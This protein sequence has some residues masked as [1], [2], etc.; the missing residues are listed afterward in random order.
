MQGGR[1]VD[2]PDRGEGNTA[3]PATAHAAF[4]EA[5]LPHLDAVYRVAR[6]AGRDPHLADDLVQETYLRAYAAFDGHR[7]ESTRSWLVAIC[8]NLVRSDWRRRAR[9]PQEQLSGD[10]A[11]DVLEWRGSASAAARAAAPRVGAGQPDEDLFAAVQ[12]RLSRDVVARALQRLPDEQ[13]Q[14]LVLMDLAGHTASEV[15]QLLGCPRGT[16]LA[17]AHRGRRRLARLLVEEGAGR[18]LL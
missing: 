8:L 10:V 11:G 4:L 15:A 12:A 16:V 6:H 2:E 1:R 13:R 18:D 14:A 9:R 3:R 5:T 17:R 7:G